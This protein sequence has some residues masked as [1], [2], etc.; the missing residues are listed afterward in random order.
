VGQAVLHR[1]DSISTYSVVHNGGSSRSARLTAIVRRLLVFC[2]AFDITFASQYVGS[3]V[4]IRSG[5]DLLSRTA[6]VSDGCKLNPVLFGKLW[7]LWGPF[8]VDM[9]ASTATVQTAPGGPALPYWSLL[10]DG[11]SEGVDAMTA[12]WHGRGTVYAFPPV[13]L[14]GEVLQLLVEQRAR[15]VLIAPCWEAQWWWPLLLEKAVMPPVMLASIHVPAVE[16]PQFVQGRRGLPSHPLG[17]GYKCPKSI[18]WVAALVQ[19]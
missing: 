10:A 8:A 4:I 7:G 15:A 16:G 18:V 11:F 19:G 3:G 13:K 1:T 6:D 5:A 17:P 9:F 14:V 2:M 12:R